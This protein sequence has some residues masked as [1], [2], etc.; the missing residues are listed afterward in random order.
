MVCF[1]SHTLVHWFSITHHIQHN[2]CNFYLIFFK[3]FFVFQCRILLS[4]SWTSGFSATAFALASKSESVSLFLFVIPCFTSLYIPY[5]YTFGLE[6]PD[7]G[8]RVACSCIE[9]TAAYAV[10]VTCA[11]SH[12]IHKRLCMRAAAGRNTA[13]HMHRDIHGCLMH[14]ED[15]QPSALTP[16]HRGRYVN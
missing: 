9:V 15:H 12:T 3:F 6:A 13:S 11:A 14:M 2:L 7:L 10:N 4:P 1:T 16:K 5:F 8:F